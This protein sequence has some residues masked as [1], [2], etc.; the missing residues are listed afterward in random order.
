MSVRNLFAIIGAVVFVFILGSGIYLFSLSSKV[1]KEIDNV[2]YD[3]IPAM[4]Y[5]YELKDSVIQIQQFTTDASATHD[6]ES[7]K[8]AKEYYKKAKEVLKKLK[9][10]HK[11]EKEVYDELIKFEQNL[12]KFFD[13][14]IKMAYTYINKGT[15]A[16]N[17]LMEQVDPYAEILA[18]FLQK[19]VKF[20]EKELLETLSL[21]DEE[22]KNTSFSVSLMFAVILILVV[23]ALI[24]IYKRITF[25]LQELNKNIL[26]LVEGEGDLTKRIEI[27]RDDEIGI[28][29]KNMNR[30]LEKLQG[31]IN[32]LKSLSSQNAEIANELAANSRQ[33]E[34][35]IIEESNHIKSADTALEKVAQ[36][37]IS[38]K[39]FALDTKDDMIK[40]SAE[41]DTTQ[42]QIESL[43][44][45]V[46]DISSSE[47][48]LAQKV[49][50]LSDEAQ[51]VK[52]VLD[53][54]KEIADQTNLLALNAAIE[55]ARAG[56]HGRGFAVVAD[57][58][59]NLA[60]KT[61]KSLSEIDATLNLIVKAIIE[62]SDD[63][64]K[65]SNDIIHL[66]DETKKTQDVIN[67]SVSKIKNSVSKVENIVD[68]F[69]EV[70]KLVK[71]VMKKMEY[72][73]NIS[74]E[75]TRSV[76]EISAAI[77]SLDEAVNRLD[78]ILQGYKS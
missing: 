67:G 24:F 56:E 33:V 20:H 39:S 14:S 31:M 15:E 51:N 65:N 27:K 17:K 34:E 63:I 54:I 46:I 10:M 61:Q 57:E 55:A 8:E 77:K 9:D 22:V 35:R 1:K 7:I 28:V 4:L 76:E 71:D 3:V 38:A 58:V 59:R 12:D 23:A 19:L 47:S 32:E 60:E 66:S 30:L 13:L 68:D 44:Q 29:A 40:T 50:S 11:D 70:D 21:I 36:K 64:N 52:S 48:E 69:E 45:K 42:T 73:L 75:N 49:K 2:V 78:M 6:L 74:L 72:V 53:V 25:T 41:L 37:V 16:G 43:T 26:D 18:K 5:F 62:T